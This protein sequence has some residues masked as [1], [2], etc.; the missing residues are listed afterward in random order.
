MP[1]IID[2][3]DTYTAALVRFVDDSEAATIS[4]VRTAASGALRRHL[5]RSTTLPPLGILSDV[6]TL[7]L[8]RAMTGPLA[9]SSLLGRARIRQGLRDVLAGYVDVETF[10]EALNPYSP[11]ELLKLL[12]PEGALEYFRRLIPIRVGDELFGSLI[13]GQAFSIAATTSTTIRRQIAKVVD[14]RLET[15]KQ[16][17]TAGRDIDEILDA[18]GISHTKGYGEMVHRTNTMEAYRHGS[19]DEFQ[20][21]DV[22]AMF[23]VWQYSGI[24][25]GR[26]RMGP[27]PDKPD[28][29]RWFGKFFDRAI[30]FFRVRGTEARDVINCRC[31]FIGINKIRWR[32]LQK[33]GAVVTPFPG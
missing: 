6:E 16:V 10:N 5:S 17:G 1:P 8:A 31:N 7:A 32:K 25:D 18:A 9:V 4:A 24:P 28:H 19:W 23:P 21:P 27:L 29:H 12:T 33:Q 3:R 30:D 13:T 22:V 11:E 20:D 15:G 14:E 2:A 26:E